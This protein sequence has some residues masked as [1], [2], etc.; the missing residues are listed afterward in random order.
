MKAMGNFKLQHPRIKEGSRLKLQAGS[1][2]LNHL[3]IGAWTF[4]GIWMLEFESSAPAA[5]FDREIAPILSTHCAECHGPNVQKGKVSLAQ[6][7]HFLGNSDFKK[8]VSPGNPDASKLIA[9]ISGD[10]P[11]M[12]KKG[13][14]LTAAEIDKLRTWITDGATWPD[15]YV[16]HEKLNGSASL[17]SLQ[18]LAPPS[19]PKS[20]SPSGN[21]ID[22]FIEARLAASGLTAAPE[23]DPR[24]LIRRLTFD[25]LGLPPTPEEVA[26]FESAFIQ[27]PASSIQYRASSLPPPLLP[28]LRRAL[29]A[30]LA[31]HRALCGHPR[32]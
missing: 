22:R 5:D 21:P 3:K 1:V 2:Y 23:A 29:G 10:E 11:E 14:K 30:A 9:A 31:G 4:L 28:P 6:R 24:T 7:E 32:L 17:W 16:L 20:S 15:G 18:P 13:P 27:D 19:I 8:V 26:A 12:P 25:F